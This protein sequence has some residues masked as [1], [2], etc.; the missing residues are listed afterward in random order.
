MS[1]STC[2][3]LVV[4]STTFDRSH[5]L[6]VADVE[7]AREPLVPREGRDQDALSHRHDRRAEQALPDPVE[8]ERLE[9]VRQ[10]AHQREEGEADHRREQHVA[11]A[12]TPGEPSDERRR[13]CCCNWPEKGR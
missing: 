1:T 10:P 5:E 13:D 12:E 4:L 3:G 7:L 6:V 8:D 11:P 2:V 9:V